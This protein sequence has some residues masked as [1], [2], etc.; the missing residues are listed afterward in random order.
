MD[1]TGNI[2]SDE[3]EAEIHNGF[4]G[5]VFYSKVFKHGAFVSLLIPQ[6][7]CWSIC[8]CKASHNW[9]G[10]GGGKK[11][12]E[13]QETNFTPLV[14]LTHII[15]GIICS[16]SRYICQR[17][18]W[19]L[20]IYRTLQIHRKLYLQSR[21][22]TPEYL[23]NQLG[24]YK[25]KWRKILNQIN[26]IAWFLHAQLGCSIKSSN[27]QGKHL[28]QASSN[29]EENI[30]VSHQNSPASHW[31]KCSQLACTVLL[32]NCSRKFYSW[33]YL[34]MLCGDLLTEKRKVV[35]LNFFSGSYH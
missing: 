22:R 5:S 10:N 23:R 9:Q 28:P 1:L 25:N 7:L 11:N 27:S 26:Y 14:P 32:R 13:K 4:F 35:E 3:E 24:S 17:Y 34:Q 15:L 29:V 18:L 8:L 16:N 20:Q 6:L 12:E 21:S 2:T 33:L 31:L 30:L 19:Y